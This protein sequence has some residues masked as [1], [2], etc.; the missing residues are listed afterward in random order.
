MSLHFRTGLD[1]G[2][3]P[4]DNTGPYSGDSGAEVQSAH[5]HNP[6]AHGSL[7]H[8][9]AAE[10]AESFSGRIGAR[11]MASCERPASNLNGLDTES[12][13]FFAQPGTV[14]LEVVRA[15]SPLSALSTPTATPEPPL[16]ASDGVSLASASMGKGS[17]LR[18]EEAL[19]PLREHTMVY[20][21]DSQDCLATF[22]LLCRLYD[23][24]CSPVLCRPGSTIDSAQILRNVPDEKD[25]V[26]L[27]DG[28]IL[29]YSGLRSLVETVKADRSGAVVLVYS[30]NRTD[31]PFFA[32]NSDGYVLKNGGTDDLI[33]IAKL[34][35]Q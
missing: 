7:A 17:I 24:H 5:S 27:L 33:E 31:A 2:G 12:S 4:F 14:P 13:G 9:S 11:P 23:L 18:E 35:G 30:S 15:I 25:T 19:A 29:D 21:E 8:T 16:P 10:E 22:A 28:S 32:A 1:P 3:L 26:V 20:F 34:V 6:L